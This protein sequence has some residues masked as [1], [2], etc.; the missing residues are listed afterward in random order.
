MPR[1]VVQFFMYGDNAYS[2]KTG[3]LLSKVPNLN[4][5]N[6][7]GYVRVQPEDV[8]ALFATLKA[9]SKEKSGIAYGTAKAT[10]R[11]NLEKVIPGHR[12]LYIA[13]TKKGTLRNVGKSKDSYLSALNTS[14]ALVNNIPLSKKNR[15]ILGEV[16]ADEVRAAFGAAQGDFQRHAGDFDRHPEKRAQYFS[17]AYT[18][19]NTKKG[20]PNKTAAAS[21]A[22]VA[23][24]SKLYGN[25]QLAGNPFYSGE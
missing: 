9:Q 24:R 22:A 19:G 2:F 18:R 1:G 6:H 4:M 10:Y 16:Y 20:Q 23:R 3:K 11:T 13:P 17:K 12:D 8:D 25:I 15:A 14:M 7:G 21:A 5:I